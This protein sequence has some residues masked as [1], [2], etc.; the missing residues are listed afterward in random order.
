M[1]GTA[2]YKI[3]D[4]Y[5]AAIQFFENNDLDDEVVSD[6]LEAIE[7]E[8]EEKGINIASYIGNIEATADAINT[9]IKQMQARK[10]AIE[11]KADS[12]RN[13][14]KMNMERTG[15]TEISCPYFQIKIKKRPA[16]VL[17]TDESLIPNKFKT[18]KIIWTVD[19]KAI[20]DAGGCEGTEIVTANT[21]IEI[22]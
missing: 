22:K 15:I 20:K 18:K 16:S 17:I 14:L 19:K 6:T 8:M 12:L 10:K 11:N 7:G 2:L 4:R 13:Y 3:S 1:A 5:L 9:A 21:R